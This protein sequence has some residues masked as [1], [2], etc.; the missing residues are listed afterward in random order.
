V[1]GVD[2]LEHSTQAVTAAAREAQIR[3]VPLW[4]VHAYHW[5]PPYGGVGDVSGG[6]MRDAVQVLLDEASALVRIHHPDLAVETAPVAG[7]APQCLAEVCPEP[8][9]LVVGGRGRGGFGGLMLGS[10]ALRLMSHARVPVMVVR[11]DSGTASA[12]VLVG[13]DVDEPVSGPELLDFTFREASARKAGLSAVH[14]WEGI[15]YLHLTVGR[16]Q[17][18]IDEFDAQMTDR[19]KRLDEV[20]APW[21]ARYPDVAVFPQLFASSLSRVLVESSRL[22][23]LV[24]LGGRIRAEAHEGMRLG[25]LAHSVLHHA[26]CP[27]VIVPEH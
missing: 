13:V 25:A 12:R 15:R 1:V 6:P 11:G 7:A 20:L 26:H 3:G 9:L 27:V 19:G 14:V 22:T 23:D 17:P 10:V 4:L 2:D 8:S 18:A 21:R 16:G 5:I 24:V